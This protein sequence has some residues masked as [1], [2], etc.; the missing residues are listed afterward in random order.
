MAHSF[1]SLCRTWLKARREWSS[2]QTWTKLPA[3]GGAVLALVALAVAIARD[4]VSGAAELAQLLYIDVDHLT[5]PV[6]LVADHR[7]E[8][9]PAVQA[10]A[11]QDPADGAAR[12]T[13]LLCNTVIGTLVLPQINHL[14][15]D[16]G[17]RP[18]RAE[19]GS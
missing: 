18:G 9:P 10:M 16:R 1:L 2:T 17:G 7:F 3:G 12:Q 13:G 4:A 14:G 15:L 6:A 8:I 5:G 11:H 19:R